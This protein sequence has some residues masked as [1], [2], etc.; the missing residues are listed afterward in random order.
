MVKG[1][2]MTKQAKFCKLIKKNRYLLKKHGFHS[3]TLSLWANGKRMP[4][5]ENAQKLAIVL[6]INVFDLPFI[7]MERNL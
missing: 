3:S 5:W 2:P 1:Y 6:K 4:G 7:K